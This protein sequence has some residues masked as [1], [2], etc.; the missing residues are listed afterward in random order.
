MLENSDLT[1]Y[2][3][4]HQL[5]KKKPLAFVAIGAGYKNQFDVYFLRAKLM[6]Q[7]NT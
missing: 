5:N 7:F 2:A 6:N 4:L 1:N 3:K